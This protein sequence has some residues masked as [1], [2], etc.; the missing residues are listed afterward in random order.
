M[1]ETQQKNRMIPT[2][3]IGA[4]KWGKNHIYAH[5]RSLI[6]NLVRVCDIRPHT[7]TDLR[8]EA[9][10]TT[11]SLAVL[12][13]DPDVMAVSV[14]TPNETH[15]SIALSCLEAGK[16]V[17]VEKPM[18]QTARHAERLRKIAERMHRVLCVGFQYRFHPAIIQTAKWLESQSDIN[19][20]SFRWLSPTGPSHEDIFQDLAVHPLSILQFWF[21]TR[22]LSIDQAKR[23]LN[24]RVAEVSGHI[25]KISFTI[26]LSWEAERK[27]RLLHAIST[28]AEL[29]I[30]CTSFPMHT[31][32]LDL[33]IE[34]FISCVRKGENSTIIGPE[35]GVEIAEYVEM[36][37]ANVR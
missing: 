1:V 2:A 27:Q 18:A 23:S 25:G 24:G 7:W 35:I 11:D 19:R 29:E 36:I 34:H 15:F 31:P 5:Q 6:S 28:D 30:D 17:L 21:P 3:V 32:P 9:L 33:E 16:H 20:L 4:G 13:K 26:E 22:R 10:K 37:L 14:V 12:L 8:G